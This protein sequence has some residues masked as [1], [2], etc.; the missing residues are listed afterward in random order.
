MQPDTLAALME[1][2]R[3]LYAITGFKVQKMGKI[4]CVKGTF[5]KSGHNKDFNLMM[6]TM[7]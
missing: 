6:T 5:R 3:Q 1:K 4:L 7:V 2:F